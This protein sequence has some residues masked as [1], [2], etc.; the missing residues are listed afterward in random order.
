M[1]SKAKQL[2]KRQ[3]SF[4]ASFFLKN[5]VGEI[6]TE[7]GGIR[8]VWKECFGAVLNEEN[9]SVIPRECCMDGPRTD[10]SEVEVETVHRAMKVNKAPGPSGVS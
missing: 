1:F 10:I 3:E 7:D 8:E 5:D 6:V 2:K 9:P 4:V